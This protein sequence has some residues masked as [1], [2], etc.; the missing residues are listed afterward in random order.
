[1]TQPGSVSALRIPTQV[2]VRI[3]GSL[4][5]NTFCK[6]TDTLTAEERLVQY[7]DGAAEV[8]AAKSALVIGGGFVSAIDAEPQG[9]HAPVPALLQPAAGSSAI[10]GDTLLQ[11]C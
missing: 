8:Q 6:G 2:H 7:K 10:S 4:Y 9:A 1:M 11:I 3:T 5:S